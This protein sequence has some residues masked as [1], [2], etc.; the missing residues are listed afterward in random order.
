MEVH[1]RDKSYPFVAQ[2]AY[3]ENGRLHYTPQMT[4]KVHAF[5][6][7]L[8]YFNKRWEA[9]VDKLAFKQFC[10]AKGLKTPAYWR[11]NADGCATSSSSRAGHR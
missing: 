2:F 5:N 6:G 11:S 4:T 3:R 1:A 7:W 10:S 9:A 8:P